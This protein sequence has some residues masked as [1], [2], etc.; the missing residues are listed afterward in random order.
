[1]RLSKEQPATP[2]QIDYIEGLLTQV[3]QNRDY[4][5][6]TMTRSRAS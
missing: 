1:M 3:Q 4:N 6:R 2:K 5:Y